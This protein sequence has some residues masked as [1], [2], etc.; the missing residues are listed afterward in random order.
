M[1]LS[2]FDAIVGPAYSYPSKPVDC[3]E[4]INFECLKVGSGNSPYKHMLVGTAGTKKIKFKVSGTSEILENLPTVNPDAIS[5]IR[6]I[7]QCSVPFMG[8]SLNGVVVVGSDAVWKVEPPNADFVCEISRLGVISEGDS[9]VS[10]IDAGGESGSNIPQKIVIADG[11]TMYSVNMDTREFNSLGN[12]V[13]Q[14]P[15]KLAYLDARVFMCGRRSD[16]NALSQRV[17][18]SAINKPD[19]WAQL[20][21]VSAS[22]VSDP[23]LAIAVAGN[24]L[25]MIGSETYELWQ[26]TS[27]SG[28]LYSPIRKVNGVASGVGAINGDSVASIA[29][30]VFFV[31]GGETGRLRIYEGSSNGTI[32]VISTD[33]MSQEFA[34]YGTLED[35][36]GMC[37]SDDGQVYYSVTFP[38][39][40]VT[41]VYNVGNRYWHK[42]SSRKETIDH[43]WNIT[44]IS[45]AFS[46]VV[47]ANGLTGELY[48]VSTHYNDDDGEAIVRKR[49]A[50]HLRS[51]GKSLRHISLELDLE[52]GNALPY[53]QGSDPQIMLC[54]LDGAGRIRREPRWKSSGTMGQYRR[55][56]K[57]N[58]LGTAVDRCYEIC[59]SDPVRWT[60]YGATIETEEGVGGR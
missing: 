30:S 7:H 48:H 26:T 58:R 32:A 17:Y 59:V 12:V 22:M 54:A 44:C 36:V 35:A 55:R 10:I 43:R 34:T 21:F 20:D 39:Q 38:S 41:W 27:S 42:R 52:C 9:Q 45:P 57:W 1:Q 18:W 29:S 8:D 46:M 14:R 24:Y 2:N 28:T 53:G 51:N 15:S 49:V 31:G 47:G 33:A 11:T 16:D 56:V 19:E 60:I 3:Q 5:R 25:W 50:P 23:V 6:G 37:W 13:P 40:D 4:C